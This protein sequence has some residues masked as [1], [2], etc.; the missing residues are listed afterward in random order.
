MDRASDNG[1]AFEEALAT[2]PQPWAGNRMPRARNIKHGF[3]TNEQLALCPFEA[4]LLFAGLWLL[5]DREGRL[6]DRPL[7]IKANIMPFDNVDCDQLLTVL[8]NNDLI[9]RYSRDGRK[10]IWINTFL[11]H[12]KPHHNEPASDLP[13]YGGSTSENG[14]SASEESASTSDKHTKHGIQD[15][16]FRIQDSD[17]TP[18]ASSDSEGVFEMTPKASDVQGADSP[19]PSAPEYSREFEVFWEVFPE[20]RKRDK[21]DA[22]RAWKKAIKIAGAG[23][24]ISAA[25]EYAESPLGRS[26][27]ARMPATWLNKQSWQDDRRSWQI[28]GQKTRGDPRGTFAA[29]ARYLKST[30]GSP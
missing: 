26:E 23:E 14:R 11:E 2:K 16:A 29:A 25:G 19:Q 28:G 30:G 21:A 13:E 7:K 15:S 22:W 20:T 27:F 8:E 6:E 18:S 5:A 9:T 10:C 4:R 24:I 17:T 3:F 12:Q 1:S